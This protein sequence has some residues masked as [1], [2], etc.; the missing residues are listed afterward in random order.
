AAGTYRI[1]ASKSGYAPLNPSDVV[2]PP[3]PMLGAGPSIKL[4]EDQKR[5][6]VDVTLAHLASVSGFVFDEIGEPIQG[7]TIQLL[8]V[9]FERG[10]RR[11]VPAGNARSTD[12]RGHYRIFDVEAGQYLVAASVGALMVFAG[13]TTDLPGYA[14]TYFPGTTD[15]RMA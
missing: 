12:D 4:G 15:A 14:P 10:R 2:L 11:L 7:A 13:S 6:D 1:A 8:R 9:R 5:A 3:L